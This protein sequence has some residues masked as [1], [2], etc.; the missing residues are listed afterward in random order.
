MHDVAR[1][2]LYLNTGKKNTKN[3]TLS[4]FDIEGNKVYHY[5]FEVDDT[6]HKVD[7]K[8]FTPGIYLIEVLTYYGKITEKMIIPE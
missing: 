2:E 4:L 8:D 3:D 7:L 1:Q 6:A 5:R